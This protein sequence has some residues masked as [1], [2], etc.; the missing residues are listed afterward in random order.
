MDHK[1]SSEEA[2]GKTLM[3]KIYLLLIY[4]LLSGKASV[5]VFTHCFFLRSFLHLSVPTTEHSGRAGLTETLCSSNP[6]RRAK[7]ELPWWADLRCTGSRV[8]PVVPGLCEHRFL[9]NA[10]RPHHAGQG[11]WLEVRPRFLI[12]KNNIFLWSE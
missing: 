5:N 9:Q 7:H 11:R 12:L 8:P 6:Q 4:L 2:V 1:P 10:C 3:L